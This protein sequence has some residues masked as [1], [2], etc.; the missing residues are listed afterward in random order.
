MVLLSSSLCGGDACGVGGVCV[1][2]CVCVSVCVR[3]FEK[4]GVQEC[5]HAVLLSDSLCGDGGCGDGRAV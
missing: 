1:Y 4:V 2:V 5:V 3:A